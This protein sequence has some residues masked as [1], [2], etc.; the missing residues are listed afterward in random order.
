MI[1][2]IRI[3]KRDKVGRASHA[4]VQ[5][6]ESFLSGR[7]AYDLW[8]KNEPVPDWAWLNVLAHAS[9]EFLATLAR[10]YMDVHPGR[11]TTKTNGLSH[12]HWLAG[13][14]LAEANAGQWNNALSLLAGELLDVAERTG[15]DVA[16]LQQEVVVNLELAY[17]GAGRAT[18]RVQ[19][20]QLVGEVLRALEEFQ[21]GAWP[22]V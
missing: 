3:L 17:S 5:E 12:R 1:G 22:P 11:A 18:A 10:G 2:R 20:W 19:P 7:Y 9:P 15:R 13:S 14:P 21:H 4:L 6:S 16:S 8:A